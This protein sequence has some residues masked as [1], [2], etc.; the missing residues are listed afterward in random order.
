MRQMRP[1]SPVALALCAQTVAQG[2]ETGHPR[3]AGLTSRTG[4]PPSHAPRS[5]SGATPQLVS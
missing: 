4:E 3:V 5:R 2:N 1:G